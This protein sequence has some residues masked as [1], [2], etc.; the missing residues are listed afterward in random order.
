MFNIVIQKNNKGEP[1]GQLIIE[2][3]NPETRSP[4]AI[5]R[6]GDHKFVIQ[7]LGFIELLQSAQSQNPEM[8]KLTRSYANGKTF[9]ISIKEYGIDDTPDDTPDNLNKTAN[10]KEGDTPD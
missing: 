4:Q 6:A 7:P 2:S 1:T 3:I 10:K 9:Q 5:K 8:S